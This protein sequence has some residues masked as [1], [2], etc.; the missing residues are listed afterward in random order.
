KSL[1][2]AEVL[3]DRPLQQEVARIIASTGGDVSRRSSPAV[4]SS[5]AATPV[6]TSAGR[7]PADSCCVVVANP[8]MRGRLG[9]VVVAFPDE[10]VAEVSGPRIEVYR[11]GETQSVASGYGNH[12]FFKQKTAYEIAISGKRVTG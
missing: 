2:H 3:W 12:F 6:V 1:N 7:S 4:T 8:A 11:A 10:V 5:S 9:R